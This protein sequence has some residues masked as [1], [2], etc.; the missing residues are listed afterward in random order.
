MLEMSVNVC[1]GERYHRR[2][3][4]ILALLLELMHLVSLHQ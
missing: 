4:V 3:R 2:L 1:E